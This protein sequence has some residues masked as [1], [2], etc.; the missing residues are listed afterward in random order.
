MNADAGLPE[1]VTMTRHERE[2]SLLSEWRLSRRRLL[3]LAGA[4]GLGLG[5]GA[6]ALGAAA[7]SMRQRAIPSTG[8]SIPVVGLGTSDAFET[9]PGE[10]LAPLKEVL[11]LFLAHGGRLV[12]TSP[13]YGNAEDV[14]GR[15][16]G[17]LGVNA[18]LF[19]ATK[20]HEVGERQG[21]EQMERSERLLRR[22]RLDLIQVHNL[23]DVDTQLKTLRAWKEAGRV[24]YLGITHYQTYAFDALERLMRREPLDFVQ[25]NYSVV[26]PDAE[27]RLL[28]LARDKGIAVIINRAFEDGRLF[29]RTRGKPLPDWAREFDC[30]SWAQFALKY[31]LANPAVTCVIPAT[32]KPKHLVDN[33]AA[34]VGR[35]P[36]A[37]MQRRMREYLQRL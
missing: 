1:E 8:E 36:D 11:R 2:R 4:A 25:F 9:V 32:S 12:D 17:E 18:K 15:L 35:L 24:R 6:P 14:I 27:R 5:L 10:S 22:K 3:Q 21:I 30:E 19:L 31:V 33:M 16:A 23:I 37:D 28:P 20:V 13:T 7:S 34:G 29:Y 26:T